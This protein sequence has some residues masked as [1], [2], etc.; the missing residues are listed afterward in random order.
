[1]EI[2]CG[3]PVFSCS[4]LSFLRFPFLLNNSLFFALDYFYLLKL[5]FNGILVLRR[6]E[7]LSLMYV[8]RID[9]RRR[10][11]CLSLKLF[12]WLEATKMSIM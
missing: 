12:I 3:L 7:K 2:V 1:L 10:I 8:M 6:K 11:Y 5:D 9:E 4:Y